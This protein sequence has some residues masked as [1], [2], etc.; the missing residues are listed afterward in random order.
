[1]AS[2]DG[3]KRG[4]FRGFVHMQPGLPSASA[5]RMNSYRRFAQR[6]QRVRAWRELMHA[7]GSC[8][9]SVSVARTPRVRARARECKCHFP[10]TTSTGYDV[11]TARLGNR[12]MRNESQAFHKPLSLTPDEEDLALHRTNCDVSLGTS[13]LRELVPLLSFLDCTVD[14]VGPER[15]V[16]SVPLLPS[17]MNQNGTH[18]GTVFYL[19]ADYAL[20]IGMF[21]VLPGAYVTGV[22]DRCHALPVQYW[23][24]RGAVTHLAPGT[25]RIRAEVSISAEEALRLR[26]ELVE[27]GRSELSATIKIS[28]DDQ[29]VAEA[30][31]TMGIY[32]DVPRQPGVRANLFQVENV[33]LSALMVAGLR[34]DSL[35]QM[36]ARDQGRALANRM[37][38]AAPQLPSLVR[39]RGL[40]VE[41]YLQTHGAAF[42]QVL[43]VGVGLDPKPIQLSSSTQRWF[44]VDLRD[45]LRERESRFNGIESQAA[46]FV[47][48]VGDI[49][50]E[51]WDDALQRAGF[52]PSLSTFVILEGMSMYF[53]REQLERLF[54]KVRDLTRASTSRLWLDHTTPALFDLDLFEVKSFLS[55]M[56]RMG[57]PF[58]SGFDDPAAV[59]PDSWTLVETATAADVVGV[60]DRVHAEYRFSVLKPRT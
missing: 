30:H 9:W 1:M 8:G 44:G 54:A 41:A 43:V 59:A 22:H 3:L 4:S 53:S 16:L 60:L 15:T 19:I 36:V 26:H 11:V 31:H 13:R 46:N 32:A 58:I 56:S 39:A 35:S 38:V 23:L 33:K 10:L 5:W 37:A 40:H 51:K 2:I 45:M 20:G 18:Q 7:H 52:S 50:L 29:L 57:E 28:Q 48:V 25:G 34:G 6:A 47:P 21:G 49:R 42:Q 12:L 55:T 14:E 17:S 27:T 24:K